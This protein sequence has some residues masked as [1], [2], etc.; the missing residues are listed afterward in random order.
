MLESGLK[1]APSS[2]LLEEKRKT[3]E[4]RESRRDD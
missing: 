4:A 2:K 1:Q 3:I